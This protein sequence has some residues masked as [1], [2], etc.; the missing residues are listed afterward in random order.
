M[1]FANRDSSIAVTSLTVFTNGN[2]RTTVNS[3]VVS[4][5]NSRGPNSAVTYRIVFAI[6]DSRIIGLQVFISC[7]G[8]QGKKGD[9]GPVGRRGEQGLKGEKGNYLCTLQHIQM[10]LFIE[11]TYLDSQRFYLFFWQGL[12][13]YQPFQNTF[14]R[15]SFVFRLVNVSAS[16]VNVLTFLKYTAIW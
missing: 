13:G 1:V 11:T 7:L 2:S 8:P 4:A 14:L 12:A 5:V 6:R 10:T 15:N 16:L 3:L 9:S